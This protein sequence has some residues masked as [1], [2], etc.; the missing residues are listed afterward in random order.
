MAGWVNTEVFDQTGDAARAQGWSP[1]VLDT[2]GNGARDEYVEPNQ[3][4]DSTKDKRIVPGSGPYA[5][6]PS[7]VDGS[8]CYTVGVFGGTPAVLR[9]VPDTGLSEIYNVPLPGFGIRG[10]DIDKS[11]VVWASLSSGHLASFDRRLCKGKLSGPALADPQ[12]LCPEGFKLYQMPGPEFDVPKG[13]P[14]ASAR[15]S[16]ARKR[17]SSSSIPNGLVM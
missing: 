11:G 13:T 10:G 4:I 2:N 9:F 16:A 17:A 15:L 14:G 6:M 8:I 3:P 1:F 7:P 12:N 5:V